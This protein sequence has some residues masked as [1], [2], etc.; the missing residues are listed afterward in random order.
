[1]V[2]PIPP[3]VR[4]ILACD[5]AEYHEPA[6]AWDV[7]NPRTV[8]PIP[9]RGRFPFQTTEFTI[10]A[11]LAGGIGTWDL[12]VEMLQVRDNGTQRFVGTS[13]ARDV[14]FTAAD[15][16]IP[17][18]LAFVLRPVRFRESGEYLF[19]IV[20]VSGAGSTPIGGEAASLRV[21][22]NKGAL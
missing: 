19:R 3:T 13:G 14:E 1:M 2:T 18:Q 11:Q 21:F 15:R 4:L 7:R 12:A 10:Y 22:D 17:V 8:F 9:P 6:D 20:A 16:L 5:I